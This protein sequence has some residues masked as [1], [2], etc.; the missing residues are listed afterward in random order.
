MKNIKK[1]MIF[2]LAAILVLSSFSVSAFAVD[3]E[4][5]YLCMSH[6][7]DYTEEEIV[8]LFTSQNFDSVNPD[9]VAEIYF[10]EE[11]RFYSGDVVDRNKLDGTFEL[12]YVGS[13]PADKIEI[14]DT[15]VGTETD[16]DN[17]YGRL[18]IDWSSIDF[19]KK[20]YYFIFFDEGFFYSSENPEKVTHDNMFGGVEM[21]ALTDEEESLRDTMKVIK[22]YIQEFFA[23][24]R[25]FFDSFFKFFS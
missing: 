11:I 24:I 14:V 25:D 4:E 9:A 21:P 13:V 23:M 16:Y 10:H 22:A 18:K 12:E 6:E 17:M 8:I 2:L 7:E 15:R 1:T 19:S 3:P 5:K 20:G